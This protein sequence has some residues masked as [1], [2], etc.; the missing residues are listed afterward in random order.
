MSVPLVGPGDEIMALNAGGA[1][2]IFT[3]ERL[4]NELSP[5][6]RHCI[7]ARASVAHRHR[8]AAL[9]G[10]TRLHSAMAG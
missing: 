7:D 10:T 3:E 1:A 5:R 4:R 2:F 6:L 9:P 8:R